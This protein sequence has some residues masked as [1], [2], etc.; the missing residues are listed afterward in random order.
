M[1]CHEPTRQKMRGVEHP[2]PDLGECM[3]LNLA[4][5]KLTNPNA[6]FV[7]ISVNTSKLSEKEANQLMADIEEKYGLPTVD[8]FRQGVGRIVD[9]L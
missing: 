4:M 1:L 5:A 9:Q 6:K 3:A 8:P 2:I 7:G